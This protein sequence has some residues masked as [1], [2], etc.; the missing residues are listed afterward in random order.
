MKN[1]CKLLMISIHHKIANLI[2]IQTNKYNKMRIINS[3]TK[4]YKDKKSYYFDWI[5]CMIKENQSLTG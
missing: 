5:L 3:K 4:K 2:I 1:I